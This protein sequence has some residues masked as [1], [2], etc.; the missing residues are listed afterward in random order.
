MFFHI[1]Y[2]TVTNN[3]KFAVLSNKISDL[4][5]CFHILLMRLAGSENNKVMR[6]T[7]PSKCLLP[8]EVSVINST[9]FLFSHMVMFVLPWSDYPSTYQMISTAGVALLCLCF[10]C[11][12]LHSHTLFLFQLPNDLVQSCSKVCE[13]G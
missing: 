7:G 4:V 5:I 13:H 12:E 11:T 1:A 3:S 10:S 2:F 8:P 6:Y 9:I